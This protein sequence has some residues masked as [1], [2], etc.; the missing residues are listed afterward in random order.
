MKLVYRTALNQLLL[1]LPLVVIGTAIGYFAVRQAVNEE[2]DEQL[3]YHATVLEKRISKGNTDLGDDAPDQFLQLIPNVNTAQLF[4]DTIMYNN[5]EDEDIP[6][7]IGIFPVKLADGSVA[8][9]KLG[10]ATVEFDDLV[11]VLAYVIAGVLLALLLAITLLNRWLNGKLWAPFHRSLEMMQHFKVDSPPPSTLLPSRVTEFDAM[12]TT[13]ETMMAKMHK[14]FTAQKRFAEQA[15]HELQ[16]PLAIMQGKLDELIQMPE[17][18]ELEAEQI[19]VLYHAR[20]RMGRTVQNMLLLSKV[21]NQEFVPQ[22]IDWGRLFRDQYAALEA[23]TE[24]YALH[25]AI[26]VDS[27]CGLR[28]H[29]VLAELVVANLLRNA[30]QHNHQNGSV[31][32]RVAHD[33]FTITNSGPVLNV[34]PESLFDRFAKGDP[35]SSGTGLGLGMVK[36]I[37]DNAGFTISYSEVAGLHCVVLQRKDP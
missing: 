19:E 13:L 9:L 35:S 36:E 37:C 16:T 29:P 17:L 3:E 22:A 4:Y 6:W 7:R 11:R 14:D 24:K 26:Q 33:G 18:G 12:N 28:L 2:L 5:A 15:A 1:A 31:N 32:V 20:D 27:P 10:R 34:D 8:M 23:L 25:F 30:V 21:G